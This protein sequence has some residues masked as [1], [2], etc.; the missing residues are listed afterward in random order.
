M[1]A[2]TADASQTEKRCTWKQAIECVFHCEDKAP[3]RQ[4]WIKLM[5]GNK[6]RSDQN[7]F[8]N[9]LLLPWGTAICLLYCLSS[10][11]PHTHFHLLKLLI[12]LSS[13]PNNL[14]FAICKKLAAELE[15]IEITHRLHLSLFASSALCLCNTGALRLN[16][17]QQELPGTVNWHIYTSLGP[18]HQPSEQWKWCCPLLC[19]LICDGEGA[20]PQ[21]RHGV[22]WNWLSTELL[23]ETTCSMCMLTG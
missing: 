23:V 11:H 18:D 3:E 1:L 21:G 7:L 20:M 17:H 12:G 13:A 22:R 2:S 6:W 15:K 4:T 19:P 16:S 5:Q 9:T 10:Q 8:S 14:L